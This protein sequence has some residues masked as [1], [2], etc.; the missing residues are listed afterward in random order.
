MSH[1]KQT[2]S[3][4]SIFL[5]Q[6][7]FKQQEHMQ[8]LPLH[9]TWQGSGFYMPISIHVDTLNHTYKTKI[10][11]QN[12]YSCKTHFGLKPAYHQL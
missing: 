11:G 6:M 12:M 7:F 9:A 1:N 10:M 4:K 3:F 8:H 2:T 5:L